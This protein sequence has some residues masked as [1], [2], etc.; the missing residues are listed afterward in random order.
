M[1]A[2]IAMKKII[3]SSIVVA[4]VLLIVWFGTSRTIP[5]VAIE[6]PKPLPR[7]VQSQRSLA[8]ISTQITKPKEELVPDNDVSWLKQVHA[9][10][11]ISQ[12]FDGIDNEPRGTVTF[13]NLT[14]DLG[15]T[16][17]L[18]RHQLKTAA[19]PVLLGE[20]HER[21]SF[22]IYAMSLHREKDGVTK[23]YAL[24]VTYPKWPGPSAGLE[25]SGGFVFN[26]EEQ[27]V[28]SIGVIVPKI[29]PEDGETLETL[30]WQIQIRVN[31]RVGNADIPSK[32]KPQLLGPAVVVLM[33]THPS[34]IPA[35][36]NVVWFKLE[37]NGN[38]SLM[39][40]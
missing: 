36:S 38:V 23:E 5:P 26:R 27:P 28:R 32:A 21:N 33:A 4:V 24:S 30:D 22:H 20:K 31:D 39:E 34:R 7:P 37:A 14:T 9:G 11:V 18:Y 29:I 2:R 3:L 17:P 40:N 10:L 1:T 6:L 16:P 13:G 35:S 15:E 19:Y 8:Q 25:S 12:T